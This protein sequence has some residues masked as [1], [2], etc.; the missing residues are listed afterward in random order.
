MKLLT[1]T[2]LTT[3]KLLLGSTNIKTKISFCIDSQFHLKHFMVTKTYM[4][5][6]PL[7]FERFS[8]CDNGAKTGD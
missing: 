1:P 4:L 5:L 3:L 8:P 2:L 7:L 6:T